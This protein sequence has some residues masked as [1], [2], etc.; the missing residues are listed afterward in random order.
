MSFW[1]RSG[2]SGHDDDDRVLS[3][4]VPVADQDAALNSVGYG[5]VLSRSSSSSGRP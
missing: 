1:P 3:V 5:S 4:S 2:L